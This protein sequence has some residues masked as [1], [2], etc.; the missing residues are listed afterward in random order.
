VTAYRSKASL[1]RVDK[2]SLPTL[3]FQ[4]LEEFCLLAGKQGN[5]AGFM[6][7]KKGN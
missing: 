1:G 4:V 7:S 5:E 6:L 2:E 3:P